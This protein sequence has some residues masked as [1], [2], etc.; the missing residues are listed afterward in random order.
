MKLW[1]FLGM[2]LWVAAMA[3]LQSQ[4]I[5][6]SSRK[7]S[8][9]QHS[10]LS[11]TIPFQS[12]TYLNFHRYNVDVQSQKS[13]R[14]YFIDRLVR[15]IMSNVNGW[16]KEWEDPE[17]IIEQAVTNMQSDLVRI[18]Q[19]FAVVTTTQSC[20][21]KQRESLRADTDAWY[22]TALQ[23]GDEV[24][25][26]EALHRRKS[27]K[28]L[29][30]TLSKQITTQA[31]AS[32]KLHSLMRALETKILEAKRQKEALVARARTA[33]T[34]LQVHDMLNSLTAT[35]SSMG[36]FA[37]MKDK[38]DSLETRADITGEMG[39]IASKSLEDIYKAYDE[40]S[41]MDAELVQMRS[42]LPGR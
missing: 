26:R 39:R 14:L 36:V 40:D 12:S 1:C 33:K 6:P 4:R 29:I 24:L 23:K 2:Q 22:Q 5:A 42:Q 19:S 7:I 9:M 30:D 8:W 18:R 27:Q 17:K 3:W 15:L 41:S 16:L 10:K 32:G 25:A 21:E 35:A 38:V 28:E 31:D 34:S 37:R 20:F 13:T 11:P